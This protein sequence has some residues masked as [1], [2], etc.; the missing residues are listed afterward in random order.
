MG[1]D[2]AAVPLTVLCLEDDLRDAELLRAR[3]ARS[4]FVLDWRVATNRAEYCELLEATEYDLILADYS[5]PDFDAPRAFEFA[6]IAG[7]EAPFICVS[8]TVSDEQAVELLRAG[9]ADYL[10]KE[11]LGRLSF[12]VKRALEGARE[13]AALAASEERFRQLFDHLTDAVILHDNRVLLANPAAHRAFGFP[14]SFDMAGIDI[15]DLIHPDWTATMSDVMERHRGSIAESE[16]FELAVVR[17]DGSPWF[18]EVTVSPLAAD[19]RLAFESA[20]HDLTSRRQREAEL[21]AYRDQLERLLSDREQSLATTRGALAS[22]TA[23]LSRTV[24]IRDPYTAG[25]Q[26]RVA[27]LAT[28]IAERLEMSVDEVEEIGIAA[29]IH[30]VGKVAIPAE[31][32]S[33]PAKLTE[34]EFELVKTHAQ[35]GYDIVS[36]A[37]LT[38]RVP[39]MVWQHHERCDGSGYPRGIKADQLLPGSKVLMVA[40][41]VE[42]MTTSRPYREALGIAVAQ[43]EIVAGAGVQFDRAVVTACIDVLA[44]GFAFEDVLV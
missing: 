18:A 38:G 29:A 34:I 44:A 5:L 1:D 30:D 11:R 22:V 40:D 39:E 33:K 6:T 4:G 42:A 27:A 12:A 17:S 21:E 28:R 15:D 19:G 8:G 9:A 41:V 16:P 14:A 32:L 7:I 24:E 20:F 43:E 31:I 26:L 23:V 36:S 2:A 25:H 3:L 10:L 13:H 37:Q 35:A